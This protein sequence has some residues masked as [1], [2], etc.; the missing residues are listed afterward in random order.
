M[1]DI[2]QTYRAFLSLALAAIGA[3]IYIWIKILGG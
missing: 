2:K 3:I 1:D